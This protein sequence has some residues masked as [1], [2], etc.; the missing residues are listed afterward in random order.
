VIPRP[1][2]ERLEV[3]KRGPARRQNLPVELYIDATRELLPLTR[4]LLIWILL[5]WILLPWV[6]LAGVLL[7]LAGLLPTALLLAGLLTRVLVLLARILVLVTHFGVLPF[8]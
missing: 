4:I 5:A 1:L 8:P 3:K 6:L 2:H 7:L